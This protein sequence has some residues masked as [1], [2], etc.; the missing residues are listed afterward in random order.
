M[1]YGT[2]TKITAIKSLLKYLNLFYDEGI[3]YRK[4]ETKRIKSD[5]IDYI[6]EKEFEICFNFIGDYEKYK[7]NALRSQLLVNIG[8]T[9]GMRLS[10]MLGL[11][12]SDI[13][14]KEIR[15]VGKGNKPRRVFFS[16]STEKI[17]EN[18]LEE[19]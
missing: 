5:Y 4:I 13:K 14:K 8:Y 6:T 10:E 16:N 12:V 17:L 9:S 18:Y 3:D 7:I 19:R 11:T 1:I 15:I 2:Y